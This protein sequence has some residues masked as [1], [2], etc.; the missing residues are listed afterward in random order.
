MNEHD[1]LLIEKYVANTLKKDEQTAF[2]KR[3][4]NEPS[5]AKALDLHTSMRSFLTEKAKQDSFSEFLT[6]V[7]DEYFMET[8]PKETIKI[9]PLYKRNSF[10][11]GLGLVAAISLF[12]IVFPFLKSP[13]LYSQFKNHRPLAITQQSNETSTLLIEAEKAFNEKNYT[14]AYNSLNK[15]LESEPNDVEATLYKGISLLE[16]NNID[17]AKPIFQS[18]SN[19]SSVFK[20]EALWYLALAHLKDDEPEQC[21][22]TLN[23]LIAQ[24]QDIKLVKRAEEL[25]ARLED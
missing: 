13:D 22:D 25:L 11:I 9:I 8:S 23:E 2:E 20:V 4:R 17:D 19:G 10:R 12:L 14:N 15:Y 7:S 18:I 24:N 6:G 16:L 5:L 21:T 3:L 1:E